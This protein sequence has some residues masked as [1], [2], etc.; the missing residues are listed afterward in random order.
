[1]LAGVLDTSG[2]LLY[3]LAS[4]TGRLD[5][6]AVLSSLYPAST[7]LLAAWLLRERTTRSQTVGMVLAMLAVVLIVA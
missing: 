7:I 3:L 6:P 4:R 2:N 5:I 1:M